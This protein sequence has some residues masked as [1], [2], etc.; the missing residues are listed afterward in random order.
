MGRK[1]KIE[2]RDHNKERE[3]L[4]QM[5]SGNLVNGVQQLVQQAANQGKLEYGA[6]GEKK[7]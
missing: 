3:W 6:P 5:G 1:H 7:K 4:L 2:V